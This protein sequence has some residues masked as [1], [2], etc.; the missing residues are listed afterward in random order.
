[1]LQVF[2]GA[3]AI[4]LATTP[5]AAEEDLTLTASMAAQ[6]QREKFNTSFYEALMSEPLAEFLTQNEDT[7]ICIALQ[8]AADIEAALSVKF[9]HAASQPYKQQAMLILQKLRGPEGVELRQDA[10]SK[11]VSPQQLAH[12][13]PNDEQ[14]LPR[15]LREER[16][17]VRLEE[18]RH[19]DYNRQEAIAADKV[20]KLAGVKNAEDLVGCDNVNS[21]YHSREPE[22]AFKVARTQSTTVRTYS[23]S[24]ADDCLRIFDDVI[25]NQDT[26]K[27]TRALQRQGSTSSFGDRSTSSPRDKVKS[28]T[29]SALFDSSDEDDS[30]VESTE[31]TTSPPRPKI[32]AVAATLPTMLFRAST[33]NILPSRPHAPLSNAARPLETTY[34]S[35][36]PTNTPTYIQQLSHNQRVMFDAAAKI[37]DA[38]HATTDEEPDHLEAQRAAVVASDRNIPTTGPLVWSGFVSNLEFSAS[39]HECVGA[40]IRHLD[41]A[42]GLYAQLPQHMSI[43]GS[44]SLTA[45][46]HCEYVLKT[47]FEANSRD[48]KL[49]TLSRLDVNSAENDRKKKIF[50]DWV[51][52]LRLRE[53]ALVLINQQSVALIY[54]FPDCSLST[55]LLKPGVRKKEAQSL[56]DSGLLCWALHHHK[57]T[58]VI[59][60][61]L[62]FFLFSR[63]VQ[64]LPP[65]INSAVRA[66]C[67]YDAEGMSLITD[68]DESEFMRHSDDE[69]DECREETGY[70]AILLHSPA[71]LSSVPFTHFYL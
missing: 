14:F 2:A 56:L 31:K 57:S 27:G 19:L 68:P 61:T 35:H 11:T 32:V 62:L 7:S 69:H 5:R 60:L 41:G 63:G 50:H 67:S 71:F 26:A 9:G 65:V 45:M 20:T 29:L 33:P 43:V 6:Q 70:A 15:K 36:D 58:T 8:C 3:S 53:M 49:I 18:M 34:P 13:T 1:L 37:L 25:L 22:P 59:L 10:L 23:P 55:S 30:S 64:L 66:D 40:T 21:S 54:L 24:A 44:F 39:K 48:G 52:Q 47:T 4:G 42:H 38:T 51:Q 16:Q 17:R 12:M 28:G 46:H